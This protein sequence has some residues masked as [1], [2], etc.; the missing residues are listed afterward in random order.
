MELL[1]IKREPHVA[2]L[3]RLLDGNRLAVLHGLV[4]IGAG[5][6]DD[7]WTCAVLT[8]RDHSFERRIVERVVGLADG[9]ALLP[10]VS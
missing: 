5:V 9:Q 4:A 8:G 2:P 10:W 3:D 6:P 7:H 1:P